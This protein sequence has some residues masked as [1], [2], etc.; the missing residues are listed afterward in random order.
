MAN[1][2]WRMAP[3]QNWIPKDPKS[4]FWDQWADTRL[5]ILRG[6]YLGGHLMQSDV[7]FYGRFGMETQR[8]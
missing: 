3:T 4:I 1:S 5:G 8:R 6:V 2:Q 7:S